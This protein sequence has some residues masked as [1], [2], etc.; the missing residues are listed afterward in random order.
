MRS[1]YEPLQKLIH[2]L[3]RARR[4]AVAINLAL[5]GGGAHGAFTWGVLDRLLEDERVEIRAV[6]GAS[7]GA[8]NA[9]ALVDGFAAG[10]C[11][12]ARAELD[13][14]WHAVVAKA[15]WGAFGAMAD[16][17]AMM[18]FDVMTRVFAPA[19]LNPFAV[20]PLREILR[21]Q[22]DFRRVRRASGIE[23]YVAATDVA[24]GEARIFDR[25]EMSAKVMLASAC[26]PQIMRP[27]RIAGRVYWDGGLS[28]NPPLWPLVEGGG[29]EETLA[30][31]L[32]PREEPSVPA[33]APEIG[34]ACHGSPSVSRSRAS[35]RRWSVRGPPE[36]SVGCSADGYAATASPS[37][38]PATLSPA[39]A[40]SAASCPNGSFCCA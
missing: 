4:D 18:A 27:V 9:V 11:A 38:K 30:V 7:A 13:A 3:T 36:R 23:L 28:S 37:S 26:L 31:L 15:R 14:V 6:S 16:R 40:V 33:T 8:F 22:I 35:L 17:P 39:L 25:R 2:A 10:G 32:S 29:P 21:A 24:T 12:G 5:Q 19:Q 20:D 1:R 34:H